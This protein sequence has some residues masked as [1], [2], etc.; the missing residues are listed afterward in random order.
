MTIVHNAELISSIVDENCSVIGS[1]LLYL[2]YSILFY[3]YYSILFYKLSRFAEK[4]FAEKDWPTKD[5]RM[6]VL[7]ILFY[8]VLLIVQIILITLYI[9]LFILFS[10][11]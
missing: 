8:F 11:I 6:I 2:N 10:S 9:I 1:I 4:D 3:L 5:A 7:S